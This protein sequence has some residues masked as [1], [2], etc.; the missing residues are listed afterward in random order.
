MMRATRRMCHVVSALLITFHVRC[1]T[2]C[3]RSHALTYLL[4]Y[5]V[6]RALR[7]GHARRRTLLDA[8]RPPYIA[9]R[10]K[11]SPAVHRS[12]GDHGWEDSLSGM[13]I[14]SG[15]TQDL[16]GLP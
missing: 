1:H 5:A 7:H 8:S 9:H 11:L 13:I 10:P 2:V 16:A 4:S 6:L 14:T 12:F 3:H 15:N